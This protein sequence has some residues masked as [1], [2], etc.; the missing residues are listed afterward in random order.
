MILRSFFS[1][2]YRENFQFWFGLLCLKYWK[3]DDG[4][5]DH[6]RCLL[7]EAE[8]L[9]KINRYARCS[10]VFPFISINLISISRLRIES[11]NNCSIIEPLSFCLRTIE[12]WAYAESDKGTDTR[13]RKKKFHSVYQNYIPY[14]H[15]WTRILPFCDLL[16]MR[17]LTQVDHAMS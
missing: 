12:S 6:D 17:T 7:L 10:H 1:H 9:E 4:F 13:L 15:I 14:K 5:L 2:T 3:F 8:I 11:W 16:C